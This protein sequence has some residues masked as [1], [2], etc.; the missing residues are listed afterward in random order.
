MYW[1]YS[2]PAELRFGHRRILASTGV[3]QG[4]PLGPLL[5]SLVLVQFLR[6]IS[7]SET[8]LLNLWYL[9][10]GTFIG[11]R[12]CLHALLSHFTESGP[13]FGLYINL[14]K[15]ELYWPSGDSSFPNF[16]PA[17]KCIN[18]KNSGLEL[19]GSPIWGPPQ[20]YDAF[21]SVQFDKI[22]AI[23][24][25]LVDLEDSQ[26][27]LHLLRSCLSVCKVTHLLRCVPSSSL[28]SFPSHFD[29]RLRECLSRILCC[30]ISDSSW[31]Q[32]TL[33]F[34]LGG[35]GLRES[36]RSAAPAFVGS[37]NSSRILVSRLVETFDIFMPFPGED[38]SLAFFE[39]MSVSVLQNSSQTD[40]QA[41][42]DDSLFKQLVSSSTIRDQAR[43]R[44]LSH[45]S[46]TSSG[47]LK[48]LPQPALGLAIPPHNFTIALRLW[49]GIPLFPSLPL[50]TCL[51]V[52]DQFGDHLLG[53]THGPLRIQRL[54]ALVS[55][56]HHALLQ[57][58]PGVLR[59]Q[60]IPSDRS[61]PG[62]I[63]HPD[64]HLG[65]PAYFDL[66]VRSTTQSA[67]TIFCFFSG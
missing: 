57:D 24:D 51:S 52:I 61:R 32:A 5:F 15:C 54:N 39:G 3:Q 50:C 33:P 23:Q 41:I 30:G 22:V 46:G 45:S 16:H 6:F 55:V 66:S 7:F 67:V 10:D 20:F 62:D 27:E 28:G 13:S 37:C 44:A 26:V 4:D 40:L 48:A 36:E 64:F 49:L 42:L 14:S 58:H 18:P 38:C 60:G 53:C 21:L 35:L 34:R 25:K 59:E 12:S 65:R 19:L 47:W 29:L 31:T 17:I 63:Y 2:Q 43:L 1:C 11:T 9:D 8:C 56:V